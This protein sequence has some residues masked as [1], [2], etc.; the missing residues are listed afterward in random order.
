MP[1]RD[2]WVSAVGRR[3]LGFTVVVLVTL[4]L[5]GFLGAVVVGGLLGLNAAAQEMG[6]FSTLN[7][8]IHDLTFAF[9]LGTAA[10]GTLAQLR[11]PARNVAS[12]VMAMIPW[13]GLALVIP[14]TEYWAAPG[15][16]FVIVVTAIFS[17]LTLNAMIFHPTG[18]DFFR[19]FRTSR[20][21]RA[22]LVLIVIAAAPLLALALTNIGLQRTVTNDHSAAGH[23]GFMA[24]FSFTIIGVG[25]L[26]SVRPDGWRLTAWVAGILPALLGVASLAYPEVDSSLDPI[27]ALAAIGWGVLFVAA[28]EFGRAAKGPGP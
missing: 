22:M 19:S 12:Q 10:V 24:A 17:V 21:D 14:L 9:L 26:A 1:K 25:L 27:W 4:G 13:V 23:Y 20:P 7:H 18:R 16:G 28:A 6:H 11:T 15:A 8:R 5:F 2:S 3:G